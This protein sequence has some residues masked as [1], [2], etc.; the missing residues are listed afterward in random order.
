MIPYSSLEP[1]WTKDITEDQ[2]RV[3]TRCNTALIL[4]DMTFK[5]PSKRVE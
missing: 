4:V 5:P 1:S 3:S 2:L